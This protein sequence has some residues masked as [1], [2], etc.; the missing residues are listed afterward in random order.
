MPSP[1]VTSYSEMQHLFHISEKWEKELW[2]DLTISISSNNAC[3]KS[4]KEHQPLI[5]SSN[6]TLN[7]VIAAWP[8]QLH[9]MAF[10]GKVQA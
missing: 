9:Q 3:K 10:F 8:G 6:A 5:I 1:S 2:A 7:A 4:C